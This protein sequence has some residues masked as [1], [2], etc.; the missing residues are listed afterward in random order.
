MELFPAFQEALLNLLSAKL[1]SF[2]AILGV[3]VGTGSV[4]ALISSSQLATAHALAEFKKLGTNLISLYV[5]ENQVAQSSGVSTDEFKL[6]DVPTL[7]A[8]SKQIQL[9]APYTQGFQPSYFGDT[10][11][12]AQLIGTTEPFGAIAK[13]ELA[14]GRFISYFDHR[15]FF[16]VIG[17]DLAKKIKEKNGADPLGK[18]VRLGQQ[19]FTVIGVLK[20]WPENL[21]ISADLNNSVIIPIETSYFLDKNTKIQNILIR[22]VKDPDLENAKQ[23]IQKTMSV[24]VPDKKIIFNSPEQII[25]IIGKQKQTYTWLLGAIGSISLIV[26]GIGVMNIMLVSVVERRR[27]IGIR[28]AIGARQYDILR[29]FL[30]ESIMLTIFGGFLGVVFGVLSSYILVLFTGWEFYFYA[31]PIILGF[32][33][34]I[35]VGIFSGFYPALRASKLNPIQCLM[36]N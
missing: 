15:N 28:M 21:F 33:V 8:S 22:L 19:M 7:A 5:T 27:E 12:E 17:A 9:V 4:V 2:L 14:K 13:L 1:R 30:I 25:N 6:A 18:Q 31:A 16:C 26:G 34:S 29:M 24:I 32:F 10:N 3:L 20:Q 35:L 11:L 36:G 23:S